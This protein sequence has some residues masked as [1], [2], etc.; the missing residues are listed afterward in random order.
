MWTCVRQYGGD[1]GVLAPWGRDVAQGSH[2]MVES[3]G[4][5]ADCGVRSRTDRPH[6]TWDTVRA[7]VTEA[8][9]GRHLSTP[10]ITAQSPLVISLSGNN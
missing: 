10:A 5:P 4:T 3:D 1:A 7:K 8:M 6:K 9:T 2:S